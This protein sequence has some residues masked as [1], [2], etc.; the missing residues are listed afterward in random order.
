MRNLLSVILVLFLSMSCANAKKK[1]W[2][3]KDVSM[4][5]RVWRYCHQDLDKKELHEKGICYKTQKCYKN[6]WGEHCK[7][8]QLF[9]AHGDIKCY[10]LNKWPAIKRGTN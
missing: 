2:Y 3:I 5:K 8:E 7:V 9:C 10:R 1:V 4:N 6:F